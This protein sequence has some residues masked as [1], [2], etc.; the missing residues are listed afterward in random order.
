MY[1]NSE[2]IV[3]SSWKKMMPEDSYIMRD[4]LYGEYTK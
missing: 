4:I 1:N 3:A 2:N